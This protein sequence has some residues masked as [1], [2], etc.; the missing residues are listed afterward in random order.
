MIHLGLFSN[1]LGS[2]NMPPK[3]VHF[4]KCWFVVRVVRI[5]VIEDFNCFMVVGCKPFHCRMQA[6]SLMQ[7]PLSTLISIP[8]EF[9]LMSLCGY[10]LFNWW[11]LIT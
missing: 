2:N 9:I 7:I 10:H 5:I 3:L 6:W 8:N 11:P 1:T 4:V